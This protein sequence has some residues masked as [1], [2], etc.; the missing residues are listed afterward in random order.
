MKN[1]ETEEARIPKRNINQDQQ[2]EQET[3]LQEEPEQ[4]QSGAEA[5]NL[6]G[7]QQVTS[8]KKKR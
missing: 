4:E 3:D 8:K 5:D 6:G 7:W 1:Q 2:N